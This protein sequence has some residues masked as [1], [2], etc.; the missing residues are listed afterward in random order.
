MLYSESAAALIQ[1]NRDGAAV[2]KAVAVKLDDST[3]NL[4]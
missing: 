1:L 2:G 3:Q 4:G